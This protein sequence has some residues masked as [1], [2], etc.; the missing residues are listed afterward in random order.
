MLWVYQ[1]VIFGEVTNPKNTK[2]VDLD[3]REKL[4]LLP[5]V[6]L[7]FWMG[8]YSE[9]FLRR[10]DTSVSQVLQHLKSSAVVMKH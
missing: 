3:L 5:L 1:R 4:I 9:P 10:M 7:I 8:I 6:G 2:L